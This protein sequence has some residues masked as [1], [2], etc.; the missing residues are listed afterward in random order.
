MRP[1]FILAFA[2]AIFSSTIVASACARPFGWTIA[3][4]FDDA[5]EVFR[6]YVTKVEVSG[7]HPGE[8]ATIGAAVISV[9]YD[10]K[11]TLKG[12]PKKNGPISAYNVALGGCGYPMLVDIDYLFFVDAFEEDVPEAIYRDSNGLVSWLGTEPVIDI[13]GTNDAEHAKETLETVSSLAS[14]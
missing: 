7:Y 10:L 8:D 6:A 4:S 12:G 11:E 14:E 13:E 5:K 9:Y 3:Q 2:C 1:L